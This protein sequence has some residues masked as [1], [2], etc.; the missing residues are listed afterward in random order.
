MYLLTTHIHVYII[1]IHSY[2]YIYY[3]HIQQQMIFV[4]I[5]SRIILKSVK[6]THT[7]IHTPSIPSYNH[8]NQSFTHT[9]IYSLHS[10]TFR[11]T[12]NLAKSR[13]NF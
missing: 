12:A 6:H 3:I 5:Q 11:L 2:I 13:K 10:L 1:Y 8:G 7:F 9:H 4:E